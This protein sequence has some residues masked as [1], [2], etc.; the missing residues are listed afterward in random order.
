MNAVVPFNGLEC[1]YEHMACIADGE[2]AGNVQRGLGIETDEARDQSHLGVNGD[3]DMER[4]LVDLIGADTVCR[5][6]AQFGM[7]AIE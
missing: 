3:P 1:L 5:I 7:D 4:G 2:G 6:F